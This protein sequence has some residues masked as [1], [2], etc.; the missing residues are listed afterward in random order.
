MGTMG[1]AGHS[2]SSTM[3][4]R[5]VA[6]TGATGFVGRSI[7]RRLVSSGVHVRAH[8]RDRAKARAV[9]GGVPEGSLTL[10]QGG[11]TDARALA[12]LLKGASA[13]VHLVGILREAPG[14]QTFKACHIEATRS[15][16]GACLAAGV[17]RYLHMSALGVCSDGKTGYLDSKWEAERL[18]RATDLDWTIF[19]PGLIH[20][21]DGEFTRMMAGWCR[22]EAPGGILPYF[23]RW[24]SDLSVPLGPSVEVAPT[25]APVSVEDVAEAFARALDEPRTIGEIYNVVGGERLTWPELLTAARDA[26]PHA[27]ANAH[28]WGVPGWLAAAGA[29]AAKQVGLGGMLPFD[30]GM[31]IMGSRDSVAETAKV[32]EHLGLTCGPFRETFATYAGAL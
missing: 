8:V 22:G 19:R 15:V 11:I 32:R 27:K 4:G 28:P 20:G 24:E 25:V 26:I 29:V 14:G 6:V 16:L 12:D 2:M 18:V 1:H 9:L 30:A 31:A 21:R 5:V 7:V 23:T 17:T 10:V 13:C 3:Q